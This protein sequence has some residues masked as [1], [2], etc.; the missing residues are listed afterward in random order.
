MATLDAWTRTGGTS[1][2]EGSRD[3]ALVVSSLAPAPRHWRDPA[4]ARRR[5]LSFVACAVVLARRRDL[6]EQ[7]WKRRAGLRARHL[8]HGQRLRR[9][10]VLRS[11]DTQVRS[12]R[13]RL[14]FVE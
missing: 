12:E 1:L 4:C 2:A 11:R 5:R 3:V 6:L 7:L 8:L 10:R 9:R 13:V 14:C